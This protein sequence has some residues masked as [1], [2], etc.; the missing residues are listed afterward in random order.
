MYILICSWKWI[1]PHVS[2][3]SLWVL[4]DKVHAVKKNCKGND[5]SRCSLKTTGDFLKHQSTV[6]NLSTVREIEASH[7]PQIHIFNKV[8]LSESN[9]IILNNERQQ[10]AVCATFN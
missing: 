7:K 4:A 3:Y 9:L 5:K 1:V 6:Y 8:G 10:S 2:F